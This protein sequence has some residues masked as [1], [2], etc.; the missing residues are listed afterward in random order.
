MNITEADSIDELIADCA[1]IPPSVR[2]SPA[3]G[4]PPQRLAPAWEVTEGCHAQVKDLDE[5]V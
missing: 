4:F 2:Q 5:Y 3:Q 1:D